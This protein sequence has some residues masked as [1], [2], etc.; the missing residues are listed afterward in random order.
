MKRDFSKNGHRERID[1]VDKKATVPGAVKKEKSTK[2]RLSI[3]DDFDDEEM[4]DFEI[5]A[6]KNARFKR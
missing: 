3:Y 4:D 5:K 2:R 1:K 6:F